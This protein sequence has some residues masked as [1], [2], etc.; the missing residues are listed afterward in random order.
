M[1]SPAAITT[2]PRRDRIA[3]LVSMAGVSILAWVYLID[4][5]IEMSALDRSAME[6]SYAKLPGMELSGMEM[7]RVKPWSSMDFI[8]MFLMWAIMM[9]GM[10]VPTAAPMTLV[11][12]AVARKAARQG[13]VLAPTGAFVGGYVLAWTVFSLGASV[14]QWGLDQAALLSPMMVST[15]PALGGGLLIAAGAYQL[16]PFKQACLQHCRAPAHFFAQHWHPGF[17]GALRMGV[18]HGAFCLG[19]CWVLMGLLFFGGSKAVGPSG[20]WHQRRRLADLSN[21]FGCGLDALRIGG[22]ERRDLR[23]FA[24]S[25]KRD[26]VQT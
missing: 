10:M 16:T 9:L 2:L 22:G 14:L 6:L 12:A 23:A 3:I 18:E 21:A 5:A 4:M 11:Y 26:I 1:N 19:C 24:D 13:A 20:P 8:M 15:S 17:W 7:L 25:L